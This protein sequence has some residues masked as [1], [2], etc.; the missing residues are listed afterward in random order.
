MKRGK[1]YFI[2][3]GARSGKSTYAEKIA[4]CSGKKVTYL[5]T[6]EALD[7]EMAVRIREHR[8]RRSASWHTVE[9]PHH[10]ASTLEEIGRTNGVVLIDCLTLLISNLL[11]SEEGEQHSEVVLAEINKLAQVA[12]DS[13]ADVIVVSNEVG[14]GVVPEYPQG[15]V[16]RDLTGWANQIMA[17]EADFAYFLVSGMAFDIKA[18][19]IKAEDAVKNQLP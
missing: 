7:E 19:H 6:A 17:R 16:Y 5:A 8:R 4:E 3:G 1:F 14:L 12:R 2:T 13:V 11:F 9:E 18:L 10:V 15:R